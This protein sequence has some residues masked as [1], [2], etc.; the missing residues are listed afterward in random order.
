MWSK[1]CLY[2]FIYA[3]RNLLE[4]RKI[5]T[6]KTFH[7]MCMCVTYLGGRRYRDLATSF[8]PLLF[9]R[10]FFPFSVTINLI[11]FL[12]LQN[13]KDTRLLLIS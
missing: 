10:C 9:Q 2:D 11:R 13:A 5:S 6:K 1:V 4:I 3:L 8:F 12:L 7:T